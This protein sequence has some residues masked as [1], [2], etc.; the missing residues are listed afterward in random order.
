MPWERLIRSNSWKKAQVR[1]LHAVGICRDQLRALIPWEF[2]CVNPY[3]GHEFYFFSFSNNCKMMWWPRAQRYLRKVS[4]IKHWSF[5]LVQNLNPSLRWALS[6]PFTP[7][8]LVRLIRIQNTFRTAI[9]W[10]HYYMNSSFDVL[11][12]LGNCDYSC[13]FGSQ[14]IVDCKNLKWH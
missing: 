8:L 6:L 13:N 1:A 10:I 3:F 12:E 7:R 14:L 11:M 9:A 2:R 4:H 5:V